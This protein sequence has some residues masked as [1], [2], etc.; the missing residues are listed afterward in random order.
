MENHLYEC[1]YDVLKLPEPSDKTLP[2]LN[3][4]ET[5]ILWLRPQKFLEDNSDADRPDGEQPTIFHI[6]QSNW[7]I[8]ERTIRDRRIKFANSSR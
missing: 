5:K 6:L 3:R 4:L 2:V 8:A 1:M 7:R